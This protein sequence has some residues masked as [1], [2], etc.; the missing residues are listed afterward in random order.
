MTT[1]DILQ[2]RKN[3][4][5]VK[6]ATVDVGDKVSIK[7]L[8]EDIWHGCNVSCWD[9]SNVWEKTKKVELN[10]IVLNVTDEF[11]GVVN[12]DIIVTDNSLVNFA[13]NSFGWS[14]FF[15]LEE[16]IKYKKNIKSWE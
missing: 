11:N 1:L 8:L 4:E 10:E 12:S 15:S 7:N 5:I 9:S 3:D 6:I 13:A 2:V 16:A 14:S